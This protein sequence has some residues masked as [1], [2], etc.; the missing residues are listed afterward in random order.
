M[1]LVHAVLTA[2][3]V[4]IATFAVLHILG[5]LR[6]AE[7]SLT[8]YVVSGKFVETYKLDL[9]QQLENLVRF[10]E[11]MARTVLPT[12]PAKLDNKLA[13]QNDHRIKFELTYNTL[14]FD[15]VSLFLS[16][17]SIVIFGGGTILAY[18]RGGTWRWFGLASAASVLTFGFLY[19]CFG[20]NTFLYS[21]HWHI[22]SLILLGA[23]FSSEFFQ[24]KH[25]Y[26][27]GA[28]LVMLLL[29]GNV[30]VLQAINAWIVQGA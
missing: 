23:W 8:A 13:L 1:S 14:E 27:L 16:A 4:L 7:R 12:L 11:R 30:Y 18:R 5:Q 6:G 24:R 29:A 28:G 26:L 19:S 21:Q 10:P 2:A 9:D 17:L 15:G 22:P 25:G 20:F 3:V